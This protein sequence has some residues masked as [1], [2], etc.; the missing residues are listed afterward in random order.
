MANHLPY[1]KRLKF[2]SRKLRNDATL[3]EV[4]LWKE[5]RAGNM[6]GYSFNRQKPILNYIVDLYCK[7]LNLVIEIDGESHSHEE[8]VIHDQKRQSELE[9]LGL[10][11]LRFDDEDIKQNMSSVLRTIEG[12]IEEHE[13]NTSKNK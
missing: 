5:L 11:F 13:K 1:N 10:K 2:L 3:A 12:F 8:V 4:L 9:D 7:K 6:Y